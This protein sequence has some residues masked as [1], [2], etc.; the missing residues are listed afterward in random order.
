VERHVPEIETLH[1]DTIVQERKRWSA[2]RVIV[3]NMKSAESGGG[4][5]PE[6]DSGSLS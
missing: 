4:A 5:I 6:T 3:S 2:P 1:S